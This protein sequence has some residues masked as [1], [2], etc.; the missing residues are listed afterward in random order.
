MGGR[1]DVKALLAKF[2]DKAVSDQ[3]AQGSPKTALGPQPPL[4]RN[5][6]SIASKAAAFESP[7][8]PKFPL[9]RT[10]GS[11]IDRPPAPV[12]EKPAFLKPS[13]L[14]AHQ[15]GPQREAK[16][17]KPPFPKPS[18]V[19]K[20]SFCV[21]RED[22][23]E[24]PALA[25]FGLRSTA[26]AETTP[27]ENAPR[28]N[29][30]KPSSFSKNPFLVANSPSGTAVVERPSKP[31]FPK[32]ASGLKPW[33][34]CASLPRESAESGR[35]EEGGG[36]GSRL[37][38]AFPPRP[39]KPAGEPAKVGGAEEKTGTGA[40]P[41]V[42]AKGEGPKPWAPKTI[43]P[44]PRLDDV[45]G[46]R[47]IARLQVTLPG[48]APGQEGEGEPKDPNAPKRKNLPAIWTLG[49]PPQKPN[50]PPN[51]NLDQFR[52]AQDKPQPPTPASSRDV[53]KPPPVP[54][55]PPRHLT[56]KPADMIPP[57]EEDEE[58]NYDD[59]LGS[60]LL[61]PP[62]PPMKLE[63]RRR[64][65]P[66]NCGDEKEGSD[67][68]MYEDLDSYRS[69]KEL[70][71][72]EK[73]REKEEKRKQEM[74]KKEQREKEKRE[75]EMRKRFKFSG[76][77]EV[78]QTV[79]V[80]M[81]YRGGKNELSCKQGEELEVIR[82]T[83]NPEGKWLARTT[84][85]TYGYIKVTCVDINYDEI[86]KKTLG[87]PKELAAASQAMRQSLPDQ[88]LYDDVA[89]ISDVTIGGGNNSGGGSGLFSS[90]EEIYDDVD[91]IPEDLNPAAQ[92]ASKQN[93]WSWLKR[94]KA[95]TDA[96][97][98]KAREKENG[99][100]LGKSSERCLPSIP[101]SSELAG[102]EDVYD[103]VSAED[104]PP[105]P[106][107]FSLRTGPNKGK[108]DDMDP[109]R[110]KKL[111]KEEKDFRKKFKFDGEIRILGTVQVAQNL[112]NKKWGNRDLPLKAG[113]VLDIVQ[114]T[115]EVKLL[116]R[117]VD[118]KFGYVQK[119]HVATENVEGDGEIYDDID[120]EC[121]YDND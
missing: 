95:E 54:N 88:E 91:E 66:S 26:A 20:H 15:E 58:E 30:P 31:T 103:D 97:E 81:D 62:L 115:D 60:E 118:G 56:S 21:Q 67:G 43:P 106:P 19:A 51:V 27:K 74:D 71:E 13:A 96:K 11:F 87:K 39:M 8:A 114:H 38:G 83:D 49:A 44:K 28:E 69:L 18:V 93:S 22:K 102:G 57:T 75:Q 35:R 47:K 98:G 37:G 40:W 64:Q 101:P 120:T 36:G 34:E 72:Q 116:C 76:P 110:I 10:G 41:A 32:P 92:D 45:G 85:G 3:Q 16:D 117:N 78:I 111:E 5:M 52:K 6:S 109:K 107:E 61:P 46:A 2:N 25:K 86:K 100:P 108:K 12:A 55:L 4:W 70:K 1:S 82:I 84:D 94:K 50:R 113:E 42:E 9:N 48:K 80:T 121:I 53:G 99:D 33:N 105:P 14:K 68:E 119:V 65:M 23:E 104:F 7:S 89:P 24:R 77:I 112:T 79:K 29:F 73:K 63:D 90:G 59:V 17:P